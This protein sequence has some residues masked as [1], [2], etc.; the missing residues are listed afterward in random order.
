[1]RELLPSSLTAGPQQ[2]AL[3]GF[4]ALGHIK[5][6]GDMAQNLAELHTLAADP[7]A[8]GREL[9]TPIATNRG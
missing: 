7:T 3:H 4:A 6:G 9:T 2:A 8:P 5:V 1:M